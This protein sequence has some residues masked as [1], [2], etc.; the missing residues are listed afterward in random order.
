MS[1][2]SHSL[3]LRTAFVRG[4]SEQSALIVGATGATGRHVLRELLKN[5]H[6]TRVGEFGRRSL[7]DEHLGGVDTSKLERKI[8]DFENLNEKEWKDGRWDVVYITLGTT[9]AAAGGAEQFEKIDRDYVL[10][11]AKAA[12]STDPAHQQRLVYLSSG[13]AS[14]SSPFLYPKS[15]GLTER[16]LASL[17]YNDFIAFRPGLLTGA[18][19]D[20]PRIAESIFGYI[21]GALSHVTSALEINT[22]PDYSFREQVADLGRAIVTAGRLGTA[23]LPQSVKAAPGPAHEGTGAYTTI[24]NAG[25]IAL[26]KEK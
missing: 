2:E 23:N 4:I 11:A 18:E 9:K 19:R 7:A 21:T 3:L 1:G 26:S 16:G 12:K 8:V 14:A 6:F 25:A 22:S 20:H 17:G 10:N 15:K 24:G 13:G 5:P